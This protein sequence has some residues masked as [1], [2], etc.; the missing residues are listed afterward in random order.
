M[1]CNQCLWL[2]EV[3]S[4]ES[5]Y[6]QEVI[7]R[8]IYDSLIGTAEGKRLHE[9]FGSLG[10]IVYRSPGQVISA[11]KKLCSISEDAETR[12][13][14]LTDIPKELRVKLKRIEPRTAPP[15]WL[16]VYQYPGSDSDLFVVT[17]CG[18]ICDFAVHYCHLGPSV[19][20]PDDEKFGVCAFW[21]PESIVNVL[22]VDFLSCADS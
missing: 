18:T 10:Q 6:L 11:I 19:Q 14:H 17:L 7:E 9:L 4:Q 1:F 13:R 20:V 3:F 21:S 16:P 22:Y 5:T 12:Y 15:A 2:Y 8:K